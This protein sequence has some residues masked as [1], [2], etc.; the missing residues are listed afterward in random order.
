MR[1]RA[2]MI[3][4][5]ALAWGWGWGWTGAAQA[6]PALHA[7]ASFSVIGDLVR[8][9]GGARVAV[10][11]LVGPDGDAHTFSP[12]PADARKVAQADIVFVN[13][14]GLE[15]WLDRLVRTAT[16]HA[17]IVVVSRGVA[18]TPGDPHAW[19]AVPNVEIYV[20]NIRDALDRAD[21][22]GKAAY[23]Q[24][25]ARY[26]ATLAALDRDI[27]AAIATIPPGR[28]K[29]ITTHDAFG[30]YQR[31]YGLRFIAPEGV[32]TEAEASP[33]DV[34]RIIDQVK[35]ERI[36]AV[37]LENISD[38]RLTEQIARETGAR[39][40]GEVYSDALSRPDEPAPT[41]VAMMRHNL[42]AF[43]AALAPPPAQR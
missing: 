31:A 19:Q 43:L 20:V 30:Y 14:L 5:A 27:R 24:A 32:S 1:F 17:P 12:A 6:A 33:R 15:G 16:V 22:A 25:A 21:P 7:V 8:A 39:I 28:R 23:D 26:L 42:A 4:P 18:A 10:D 41:Y 13:G 37:F 40:G 35:A 38:N 9:V 11:T 34:A 2:W 36:P 3:V 29:V